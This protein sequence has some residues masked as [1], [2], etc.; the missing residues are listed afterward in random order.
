MKNNVGIVLLNYNTPEDVI[1]CV[2]SIRDKTKVLY[3]IYIVDN[4]SRDNSYEIFKSKYSLDE[5][6]LLMK[7]VVNNGFSAGNNIGIK[8]AIADGYNYI[9]LVNADIILDN[10]AISILINKMNANSKIRIATPSILTPNTME[11]TQFARNKL[12]YKNYLGEKTFLK[13]S[14][15]FVTKYPRM[16]KESYFESD[17]YFYGMTY[18]CFY[19]IK[20]E[21]LEK[22]NYL[23]EDVFLFN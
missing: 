18:G 17:F 21:I 13:K 19:I 16:I 3:K 11:D 14:K 12:T 8:K 5:D 7:S 20:S 15:K 23:D 6:I 1:K 9:C 10:D 4:N 2:E 22:I